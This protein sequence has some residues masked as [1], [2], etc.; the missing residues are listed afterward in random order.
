MIAIDEIFDETVNTMLDYVDAVQ[1]SMNQVFQEFSELLRAHMWE[2][3]FKTAEE[4][5]NNY[6]SEVMGNIKSCISTWSES[7]GSFVAY[8]KAYHMG[9]EALEAASRKQEQIVSEIENVREITLIL[10]V[11]S[12]LDFSRTNFDTAEV[13]NELEMIST[14]TSKV[15][16]I[17]EDFNRQ[18]EQQK[19][20]NASVES[21]IAVGIVYGETISEFINLATKAIEEL[22]AIELEDTG[23]TTEAT[24]EETVAA[25]KDSINDVSDRIS[26]LQ[27]KMSELFS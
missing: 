12:S 3:L 25:A 11:R 17:V 4:L 16:D 7:E 14:N 15:S 23:K 22:I 27:R 26:D 6:N 21:L 13:N 10:E 9:D 1:A 18:L 5:E 19:G 24:N 2:P 8:C 20:E